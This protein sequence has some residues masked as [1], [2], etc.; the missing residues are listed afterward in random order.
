M[1]DRA[2]PSLAHELDGLVE[3]GADAPRRFG[4]AGRRVSGGAG[5][6]GDCRRRFHSASGGLLEGLDLSGGA[7][8]RY[9][10]RQGHQ[11]R[12]VGHRHMAE[13]LEDL[14]VAP[15]LLARLLVEV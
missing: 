10:A 1:N 15:A 8:Q 4:W 13:R 3:I 11:S 14:L 7:L 12:E 5:A 6:V 2:V 9:V